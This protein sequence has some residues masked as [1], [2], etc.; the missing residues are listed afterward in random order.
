MQV[1]RI[2]YPIHLATGLATGLV[3]GVPGL[4]TSLATSLATPFVFNAA[5][6][7]PAPEYIDLEKEQ[8]V[9]RSSK[10]C[11]SNAR[12]NYQTK[13]GKCIK[14]DPYKVFNR[15]YKIKDWS[16]EMRKTKYQ[17]WKNHLIIGCNADGQTINNTLVEIMNQY[18]LNPGSDSSDLFCPGS[19]C[20]YD[21]DAATPACRKPENEDFRA[22]AR[23]PA[24]D[25][26]PAYQQRKFNAY[27]D[28]EWAQAETD[29]DKCNLI[30][31]LQGNRRI[32]R[33]D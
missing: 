12:D 31:N 25:N 19:E 32:P 2:P 9:P 1:Q 11:D 30:A 6:F 8:N 33:Y 28:Q 7:G 27:A 24:F 15:L 26:L 10:K 5:M 18:R 23:P 20:F 21:Y 3:T 14:P 29:V 17:M 4:T 16:K 22:L 13:K